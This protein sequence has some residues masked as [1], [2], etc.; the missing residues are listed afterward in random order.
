VLYIAS[1]Q[2]DIVPRRNVDEII[3]IRPSVKVVTIAG[4]HL[5]MYTNPQSAARA[6]A[7]FIAEARD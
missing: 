3:R 1:S 2:D 4:R 7:K 6:I 5:A